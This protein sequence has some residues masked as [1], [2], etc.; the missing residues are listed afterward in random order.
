[1]YQCVSVSVCADYLSV[2]VWAG[3]HMLYMFLWT[4]SSTVQG[5]TTQHF[6]LASANAITFPLFRAECIEELLFLHARDSLRICISAQSV[7]R[8]ACSHSIWISTRTRKG[9]NRQWGGGR[10]ARHDVT[11]THPHST[12]ATTTTTTTTTTTDTHIHHFQHPP[13]LLQFEWEDYSQ[14]KIFLISLTPPPIIFLPPP[15]QHSCPQMFFDNFRN[16]SGQT[17]GI[18]VRCSHTCRCFKALYSLTS[19]GVF[20]ADIDVDICE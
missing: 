4:V 6:S 15:P 13:P 16:G 3:V 5:F 19:S 12:T 8:K 2:Y 17:S 9:K 18:N 1:M 14:R 10:R 11:A 20:Q 7:L